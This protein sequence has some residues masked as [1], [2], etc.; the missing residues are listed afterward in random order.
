MRYIFVL[1]SA[2]WAQP[3]LAQ[4]WEDQRLFTDGLASHTLR[5]L[6]NTDTKFF[7]P[8]IENFLSTQQS[9]S[10]DYL[11]TSSAELYDIFRTSPEKFDVVIS[12]AMDLQF[13]LTND[14]YAL[15]LGDLRHP[16]WAQWRQSL[17]AF[18]T[19]PAAIV[20]N[21]AAFKGTP[22]PRSRQDLIEVLR[23]HPKFFH[24]RV[25]TYD[26]RQSGLGYFFATQD[27]RVSETYWRL[28]EVIGSL[29]ARLYCCS[30]DMI[31]DLVSG[32]I[33]V[34]YNVLGSYAAA[35]ENVQ[36]LIEV[37]LPSNFPTTMMRSAFVSRKTNL[38]D[39]AQAFVQHL[40]NIQADSAKAE[41]FPLPPLDPNGKP[42]IS[43]GPALMTYLDRLKRQTFIQEWER[44]IIQ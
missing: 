35:Q 9:V 38:P 7:A 11:V 44:A 20:I 33:A 26:V 4:E 32:K 5:I 14:G 43:L 25:G 18:S 37:I 10:V 24:G 40:V 42:A 30:G 36:S 21:R 39:A 34:A 1:I 6:S 8:I 13:K 27:A 22:I 31:D 28:T 19:E 29:D 15:A 2:L 23:A 16:K 17:F 12:S 41:N 3:I